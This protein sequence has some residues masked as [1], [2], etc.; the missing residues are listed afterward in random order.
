MSAHDLT[1]DQVIETLALEPLAG[2]GG[3]YRR[4]W[5]TTH[6]SAIYFLLRPRDFSALHRLTGPEVWHH[7]S[8]APVEMLL[9][10]PDGSVDR[11][12]LGSGLTRGHR[13]LQVV[14]AGVWMGAST[15]GD[16]SLLGATMAPPFDP[17]GFEL[18]RRET[19]QTAYPSVT[20]AIAGLTREQT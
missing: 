18:G 2:E 6:G 14:E 7:Y 4:E 11:P 16:W 12:V 13:P 10:H 20:A 19:L 5:A 9:L 17:A 3:M 1:A 8:G 15:S